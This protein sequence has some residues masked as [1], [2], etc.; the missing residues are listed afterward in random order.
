[1]KREN[2]TKTKMYF[3]LAKK[4]LADNDEIKHNSQLIESKH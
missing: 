4:L 1:M 2:P 3:T